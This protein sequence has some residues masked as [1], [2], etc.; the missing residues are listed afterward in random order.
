MD[1]VLV[2]RVE[3]FIDRA[4]KWSTVWAVYFGDRVM[5]VEFTRGNSALTDRVEF[6]EAA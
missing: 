4:G 1:N 2:V 6:K 3:N 5:T